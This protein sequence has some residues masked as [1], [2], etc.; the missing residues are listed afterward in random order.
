MSNNIMYRGIILDCQAMNF[1]GLPAQLGL[2][3]SEF[4]FLESKIVSAK[5]I[6][7]RMC[8]SG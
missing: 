3:L 6:K 1:I 4:T 8:I 7:K 5:L 2:N